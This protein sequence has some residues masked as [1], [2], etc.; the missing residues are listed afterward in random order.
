MI[1][2]IILLVVVLGIMIGFAARQMQ[3]LR[4]NAEKIK[5]QD[6]EI[7]DLLRENESLRRDKAD[8]ETSLALVLGEL[9]TSA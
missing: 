4:E 3:D 8:H 7:E 6:L 1:I 5:E 2:V 9:D